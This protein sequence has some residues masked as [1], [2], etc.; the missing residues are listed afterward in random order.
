MAENTST[1]TEWSV[2]GLLDEISHLNSNMKDRSL[3]FILGAGASISSGIPAGGALAKK[4]L[5]EIYLRENLKT[6]EGI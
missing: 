1:I 6:G 5:E 3:A 4:W 2:D